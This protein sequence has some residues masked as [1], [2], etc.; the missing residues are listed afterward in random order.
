LSHHPITKRKRNKINPK[1]SI[2]TH[3][4]KSNF[5]E[6]VCKVSHPYGLW[7]EIHSALHKLLGPKLCSR[8]VRS[9]DF[10]VSLVLEPSVNPPLIPT[11]DE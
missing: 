8:P 9:L 11:L 6:D 10:G 5:Q 2:L 7:C 1:T 4:G 3:K